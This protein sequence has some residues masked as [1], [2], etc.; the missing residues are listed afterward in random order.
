MSAFRS[1]RIS[2][3]FLSSVILNL[4]IYKRD[5]SFKGIKKRELEELDSITSELHR[6]GRKFKK[7]GLKTYQEFLRKRE[8]EIHVTIKELNIIKMKIRRRTGKVKL[9]PVSHKFHVTE[10]VKA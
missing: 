3:D 5:M 7:A 8:K 10:M 2:L 9:K 4:E 6:I 1:P